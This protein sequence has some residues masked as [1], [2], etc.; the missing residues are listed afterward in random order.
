M[1]KTIAPIV[2]VLATT[3]TGLT[4]QPSLRKEADDC[5]ALSFN[6]VHAT[7]LIAKEMPVKININRLNKQGAGLSSMDFT[8]TN[9]TD[10]RIDG[11]QGSLYF[12]NSSGKL[13]AD[14]PWRHN[15]KI[16]PFS[17]KDG[18]TLPWNQL[19]PGGYIVFVLESALSAGGA[20][21]VNN[22]NTKRD[23]QELITTGKCPNISAKFEPNLVLAEKEIHY[24]YTNAL[25]VI[26]SSRDIMKNLSIQD[27]Q[28]I[29]IS[30]ENM[31][32]QCFADSPNVRLLS[33]KEISEEISR[34]GGGAYMMFYPPQSEGTVVWLTV[35][36]YTMRKISSETFIRQGVSLTLEYRKDSGNLELKEIKSVGL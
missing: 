24:L 6:G 29:T 34:K 22:Q 13:I 32:T 33:Q 10:K 26:M 36:Y 18:S 19:E 17:R 30:S 4:N 31:T 12:F 11:L 21:R 3:V 27:K 1:K 35:D 16:Q 15:D 7:I 2:L 20:W 8:I 14:E 28:K 9:L 23:V 5:F 25:K